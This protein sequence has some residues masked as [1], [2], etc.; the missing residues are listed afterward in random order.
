ME[1]RCQ[2]K[3]VLA[4]QG[5][6]LST[7]KEMQTQR[8]QGLLQCSNQCGWSTLVS[9]SLDQTIKVWELSTGK[10][11]RTFRG[12]T[13]TVHS[14]AMSADGETLVSGSW[15]QTIKVWELSTG[16]EMQTLR[17]HIHHVT[18]VAISADGET[19]VSGSW[20]QTIKVWGA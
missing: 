19:L 18:S 15:D 6:G 5:V 9:G 10:E 16:K 14:I 7:G 4:V 11:M 17:E 3:L 2:W 1:R 12:H 20:D 13:D 8:A